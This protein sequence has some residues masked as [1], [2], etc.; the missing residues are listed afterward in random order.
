MA[1]ETVPEAPT[2][3]RSVLPKLLL[4]VAIMLVVAVTVNW[5]DISAIAQGRKTFKSV[6]YGKAYSPIG[7]TFRFPEPLGPED[8]KVKAQ[9]IAQEGNSC[10][11]ALVG[12]WMGVGDLEPERLRV[13][14]TRQPMPLGEE[15]SGP[16]DE[17]DG[18]PELGCDAGVLINGENK[19]EL[20]AGEE[21][22]TIYLLGPDAGGVPGGQPEGK[23]P[24]QPAPHGWTLDD[25][26]MIVNEAIEDAYGENPKL[27]AEA[28]NEAW[29]AAS[30][31]IPRLNEDGSPLDPPA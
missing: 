18:P 10:H 17:T 16:P 21:K 20:G 2:E 8:A 23:A 7:P 31:R 19:F 13:E 5:K 26:A 9:V 30:D 4:V 29:Q 25:V 14:F 3:R 6:L 24:P 22:R 15:T 11:E 1:E 28:I 12:L 27:T